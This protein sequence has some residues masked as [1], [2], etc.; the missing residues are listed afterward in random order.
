MI[1]LIVA[2]LSAVACGLAVVLAWEIGLF[3][4]SLGPITPPHHS[5][6]VAAPEVV[7][8]DHTNEWVANIL[9]RP[10]FSPDRRPPADGS[11][12]AGAGLAGLPRL[13]GVMVGPFGRSAIFAPDGGKPLIVSEGGRIA[14]WTVQAIRANA[15]EVIGPDGKRTLEPTFGNMPAGAMPTTGNP[16]LP[17][18]MGRSQRQ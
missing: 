2:G 3:E 6:A 8:P 18:R 10:L 16:A 11:V 13:S 15:V 17:Q 14:A 4:P 7:A 1:R 12:V 5:T 9:S